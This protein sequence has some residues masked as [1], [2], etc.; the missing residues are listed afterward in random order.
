MPKASAELKLL[1]KKFKKEVGVFLK[2]GNSRGI[3][4]IARLF[5]QSSKTKKCVEKETA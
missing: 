2:K 1:A 4:P 5:S 3:C